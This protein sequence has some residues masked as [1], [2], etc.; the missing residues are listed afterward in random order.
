MWKFKGLELF[1]RRQSVSGAWSWG[2]EGWG[3]V[4]IFG[5]GDC[6]TG[7]RYGGVWFDLGSAVLDYIQYSV[8]LGG[9]Y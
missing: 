9:I 7:N 1:D 5:V 3:G 8:T 2:R 6:F 4:R